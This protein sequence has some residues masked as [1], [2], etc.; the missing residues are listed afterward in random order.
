VLEA[1]GVEGPRVALARVIEALESGARVAAVD[2]GTS[3][4][5]VV[6]GTGGHAGDEPYPF[7]HGPDT[8]P[9]DLPG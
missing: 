9:C 7:R 4:A 1:L 8:H 3:L 2:G 5:E 6:V